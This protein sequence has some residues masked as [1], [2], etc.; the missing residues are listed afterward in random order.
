MINGMEVRTFSYLL[1]VR[2]L[3]SPRLSS[4]WPLWP[5]LSQDLIP[6]LVLWAMGVEFD[7]ESTGDSFKSQ[8]NVSCFSIELWPLA[9]CQGADCIRY[10]RFAM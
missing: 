1:S 5:F 6:P 3:A 2:W 9:F 4:L 10:V 8:K 7:D